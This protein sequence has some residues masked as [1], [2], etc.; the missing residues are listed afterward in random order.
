ME[1]AE[2]L[3]NELNRYDDGD[4]MIMIVMMMMI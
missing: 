1:Q 3:K 4:M 2:I